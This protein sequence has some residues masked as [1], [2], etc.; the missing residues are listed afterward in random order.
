M[1]PKQTPTIETEVFLRTFNDWEKWFTRLREL[2][3]R[4]GVWEYYDPDLANGPTIRRPIPPTVETTLAAINEVRHAEYQ[5]QHDAWEVEG[6][7]QRPE[8]QPP[9]LV[10]DLNAQQTKTLE[11]RRADYKTE[12]EEY[13]IVNTAYEYVHDW[14]DQTVDSSWRALA[15]EGSTARELIQAFR[16]NVS[17]TDDE[18]IEKASQAYTTA[19]SAAGKSMDP[20]EWYKTWEYARMDGEKYRIPEI[21]GRLAIRRFLDAVRKMSPAFSDLHLLQMQA[22]PD[23][24]IA[25]KPISLKSIGEAFVRT[26]QA[27]KTGRGGRGGHRI[28]AS[29]TDGKECPCRYGGQVH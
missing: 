15:S 28:F 26:A 21:Q 16:R 2:A 27:N 7:E 17:Q 9:A 19:L 1:P 13:K 4:K 29:P 23:Y 10:T 6:N 18:I 24:H 8:P 3:K 22:N 25:G 14:I 12:L 11:Q 20:L 5:A